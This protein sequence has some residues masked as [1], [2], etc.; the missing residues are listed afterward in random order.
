[1][2][3]EGFSR[4]SVG[5][6]GTGHVD[7]VREFET[8]RRGSFSTEEDVAVVA[9]KSVTGSSFLNGKAWP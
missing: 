2:A 5:S 4:F 9:H 7:E 1:M 8:M 6:C 3:R